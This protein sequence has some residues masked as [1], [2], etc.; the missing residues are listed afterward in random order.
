MGRE[1]FKI[2]QLNTGRGRE[3][4]DLLHRTAEEV[5][6]DI[7]VIQEPY[8]HLAA[9]RGWRLFAHG[10]VATMVKETVEAIRLTQHTSP[11]L[12]T[13]SAGGVL[14]ANAYVEPTNGIEEAVRAVEAMSR[15]TT[16][17]ML[18]C[19][20][21]NA[22]SATWGGDITDKRGEQVMDLVGREGLEVLNDPFSPPTFETCNGRSWIDVTLARNA[23]V[24]G[25]EVISE[26]SL[27]DH[28][29]ISY[30][31][32][33]ANVTDTARTPVA[34]R[35]IVGRANWAKFE[36][37]CRQQVA[38]LDLDRLP[39]EES[40][41]A[42]QAA[43]LRACEASIPTGT[44]R[45]AGNTAWWNGRLRRLRKDTRRARER[46]QA[47]RE[48]EKRKE[49]G[50]AYRGTRRAYKKAIKEAKIAAL[51]K[52]L[53]GGDPRDPWGTAFKLMN[54][55][56]RKRATWATIKKSADGEWTGDR[57]TT[58]SALI[59]KYFP[60]DDASTDTEE[61]TKTRQEKVSWDGQNNDPDITDEEV[62]RIVKSRPKRKAPGIDGFPAA[63]LPHLLAGAGTELRRVL[64]KCLNEGK[65]PRVWKR[66]QIAW[67]PKPNGQELRPI[68][69]LPTI[70]KLLD[71]ILAERLG[72]FLE[73][74]G[75]LS[76]RQY[77][78][79]KRRG[80]V[81]A[82]G[83]AVEII[84][85][86]KAEGKHALV[87]A[88]D[89]KN[90]FN[91]AWYPKLRRALADTG[92]P[93]NLARAV[94]SF[95]A[96]RSVESEG[97]VA[98]TERGCPQGS[99]LGPI[100]WLVIMEGWFRAVD[101]VAAIEGTTIH[102]QAYAD[103]Q[104]IIISGPSVKKLEAT[105]ERA[106]QASLAWAAGHKLQYAPKKTGAM[107][108]AASALKRG[109]VLKMGDHTV[110]AADTIKYLGVIIDK[111][112]LW[113]EHV[114]HVR[115]RLAAAAHRVR[116]VAGKEWGAHPEIL[117]SIYR[118]AI[119]PALL[120]AAEVW[121]EKSRDSRVIKHL[122]AAQ[123]PFLLGIT[124]AYR[125]TSNAAIQVIAG[126]APLHLE[127][128]ARHQ[129]WKRL[130]ADTYEGEVPPGEL[131]HPAVPRMAWK[132]VKGQKTGTGTWLFSDA[133]AGDRRVGLAA[134]AVENGRE[135]NQ[136]ARWAA[137][138]VPSHR[139][140]LWALG[141]AVEKAAALGS[142]AVD[143]ATD[144]KVALEMVC[145]RRGR[146]AWT[147]DRSIRGAATAG[148]ELRLWW[149]PGEARG[150]EK[151]DRL[152]KRAREGK[153]EALEIVISS[154]RITISKALRREM[155]ETWKTAWAAGK[156]GRVT[157]RFIQE[158]QEKRLGWKYAA[159][160]LLTGHG[161]FKAY[162]RRFRL[163]EGTGLCS[164]GSGELETSE[165]VR[166]TCETQA[167]VIARERF[168]KALKAL[169]RPFP[170]VVS[171]DTT[172][173][174]VAAFNQWAAEVVELA[175]E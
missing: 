43:A 164:C 66:A 42:F 57:R 122:A 2:L 35:Y 90:A 16:G 152:A 65:F 31:V 158:P 136:W 119:R 61:N 19:G 129:W 144:S 33:K 28:R 154:C 114:K 170:L 135:V 146:T 140:E 111:G 95:L 106:W 49:L 150:I 34:K 103:D 11:G 58:A 99:C 172:D 116:A 157:F 161:P 38:G 72:H 127:A 44:P 93:T 175:D 166:E 20:D 131:P 147:I 23:E 62:T 128:A 12:L 173:G 85:E 165:H 125:T 97:V 24:S 84:R 4:T 3:A 68:C 51:R 13:I 113:I 143:I 162:Y 159:V 53:Q 52:A 112:L 118:G 109:P 121:G 92:C 155:L 50:A 149:A 48:P 6:A 124:K 39:A 59:G 132:A 142:P 134:V 64:S 63:G 8:R 151:A 41:A 139:A 36:A 130:S 45:C 104:L 26:E 27:S 9:W 56:K 7:V 82:I 1:S 75:G 100:L 126:C 15:V 163:R 46:A 54:A 169:G 37:E 21:L 25:W 78:F 81:D 168:R 83:R 69:L 79:R 133:S 91:S 89:I 141:M 10:K 108:A 74:N 55:G 120:Y 174:E 145:E 110:V 47:E 105:W 32:R 18:V 5:E 88:L 94:S 115:G 96:D 14:V 123:R 30:R 117:R 101:G 71:K 80:T 160:C 29:L 171:T 153:A 67:L 73:S 60:R 156:T 138:D 40:A 70:G 22:K 107:F 77:G 98:E 76:D 17:A 137:G 86:T 167:R 87:V 102:A 148:V